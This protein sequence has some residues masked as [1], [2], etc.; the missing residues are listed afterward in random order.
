MAADAGLEAEAE[1]SLT[2]A[3][4]WVAAVLAQVPSAAVV[5]GPSGK[6]LLENAA[7]AALRDPLAAEASGPGDPG[8]ALRLLE[9]DGRPC[10]RE[11]LPIW[12][13]LE[14]GEGVS[15]RLL[16]WH[17]GDGS[18]VWLRVSAGPLNGPDGRRAGAIAT[19]LDVS[20]EMAAEPSSRR[21]ALAGDFAR[22]L[23]AAPP[24]L[25]A[26]R[27]AVVRGVGTALGDVAVLLQLP[28]R[29]AER[30][31]AVAVYTREPG[32]EDLVRMLLARRGVR[33]NEATLSGRVLAFDQARGHSGVELDEL[34]SLLP[35][36][37]RADFEKLLPR[38]AIAAPVRAWGRPRGV[39]VVSRPRAE[40]A[41]APADLALL[42]ELAGHAGVVLE[43]TRLFAAEQAAR[44]ASERSAAHAA[45]LQAATAALAS[46]ATPAQIA[47]VVMQQV[48]R[49]LGANGAMV[50]ELL[51]DG[52]SLEVVGAANLPPDMLELY[53]RFSVDGAIPLAIA[54]R[55]GRPQWPETV[56]ERLQRY[57]HLRR[58]YQ[59]SGASTWLSLPLRVGA[60]TIGGLSLRFGGARDLSAEDRAYALA[61]ATLSAQALERA[62][63]YEAALR[64]QAAAEEA[65]RTRDEFLSIASHELRTPVAAVKGAAQLLL[66]GLE[67]GTAGPDRLERTLQNINQAS[68]RLAE[69]VTDLL[70]V[71]RMRTGQLPF[72]P[73]PLDLSALVRDGVERARARHEDWVEYRLEGAALPI[74]LIGDAARL[75]QVLDNLL[76]NARKYSPEGGAVLVRLAADDAGATVTV[77]DHG[78]GLPDGA[79][80]RIFQPFGRTPNAVARQIPGLGL[81]LPICRRIVEQHGGRIWAES[82]GEDQG[83]CI[84]VWLP[85]GAGAPAG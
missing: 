58:E 53:H 23:A 29:G 24:D 25:E 59:E 6:V 2:V 44:K 20:A 69:M 51:D 15:D 41:Y 8:E 36:E 16:R 64:A 21:T 13:A 77:E 26:V 75:E 71:S 60:R 82:P 43:R 62:R 83:T 32:A 79:A 35:P 19:Y 74:P 76:E 33:A 47:D 67:R 49:A 11:D 28:R 27:S 85:R 70:D 22:A 78:I 66:R 14:R 54:V 3:H 65:V 45:R 40:G 18:V 7:Y 55:T 61:V 38:D 10:E 68:D 4:G 31:E 48:A 12:R 56:E 73:A 72:R 34:L 46:A 1:G 39:I 9:P 30:L 81:G 84:M 17:R 52:A 42:E 50:V 63:L 80:E 37:R 57:P 5:V